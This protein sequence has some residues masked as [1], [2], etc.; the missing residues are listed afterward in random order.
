M[1]KYLVKGTEIFNG[2][3]PR[4]EPANWI[5]I[6]HYSKQVTINANDNPAFNLGYISAPI[7]YT[8]IGIIPEENGFGDQWQV[9]YATYSGAVFAKTKSWYNASLTGNLRCYAVYI[10]TDIYNSINL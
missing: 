7:G 10:K 2:V 6:R 9:T 1:S 5:K 8:F 3:I 4:Y